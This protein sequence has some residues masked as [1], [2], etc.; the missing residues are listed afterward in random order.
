MTEDQATQIKTYVKAFNPA[1]IAGATLDLVVDTVADRVL[2][3]LNTD[4]LDPRIERI[5][6]QAVVAAYK[7][8][9]S[10]TNLDIQREVKSVVDNGQHVTFSDTAKTY[11]SAASDNVIIS[12]FTD[13]LAPY[14]RL[15]VNHTPVQGYNL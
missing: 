5:V 3:Y 15:H 12:G 2:L 13:L 8:V 4:T 6:A 14:R 11:V 10:D 7:Q 1:I 9:S